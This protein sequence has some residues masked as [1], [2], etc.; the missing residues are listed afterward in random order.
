MFVYRYNYMYLYVYEATFCS[1]TALL[2]QEALLS[3]FLKTR[4]STT[5]FVTLKNEIKL[6]AECFMYEDIINL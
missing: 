3:L 5:T 1:N 4:T 6:I 2:Q